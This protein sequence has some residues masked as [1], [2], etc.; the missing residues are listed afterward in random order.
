MYS[1]KRV[2]SLAPLYLNNSSATRKGRPL[3]PI[4]LIGGERIYHSSP[5]AR[6]GGVCLIPCRASWLLHALPGRT[7]GWHTHKV[8][9]EI[10]ARPVSLQTPSCQLLASGDRVCLSTWKTATAP[11]TYARAHAN[12]CAYTPYAYT[13]TH[14][15][16]RY[17]IHSHAASLLRADSR[18]N[19]KLP[20]PSFITQYQPK[21]LHVPYQRNF[22]PLDFD[23]LGSNIT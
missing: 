18:I 20:P 5:Q 13:H 10:Y 12:A 22:A 1:S 6:I 2:Q 21:L 23:G 17:C 3:L 19:L 15:H 8:M 11:H 9:E 16:T 14:T 4:W 7:P